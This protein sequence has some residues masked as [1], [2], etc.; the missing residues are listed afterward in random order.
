MTVH[1]QCVD[2]VATLTIDRPERLNSIDGPTADVLQHC[3][4][5]FVIDDEAKVLVLTGAG[6]RAFCAGADL[7]ALDTLSHRASA[8]EGFEGFTRLHSP[9]PT[10][11]AIGGHC[12]AGGL[13]LALW[14]DLRIASTTASF[15]VLTRRHGLPYVD[16]GTQRLP[17]V[18][19]L[20]RALDLLMTGRVI[21][22]VEAE[23]IGLVNEL[24]EP[25][26][27]LG[28]AVEV[29]Q[30]IVSHP[31]DAMLNDR[32]AALEGFGRPLTE[33]LAIEAHV[34]NLSIGGAGR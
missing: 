29:A 34:H 32:R 4:E 9:K 14:C 16:G 22:A 2:G 24:V 17:R 18:I 19:G 28:R 25:G 11:A 1:Y 12:V 33:G 7:K 3:F 8:P 23:R 26:A 5:E 30:L 20:P 21:D 31:P 27:H 15:G 10:I 6:E 13:E